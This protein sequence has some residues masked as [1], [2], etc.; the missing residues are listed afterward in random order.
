M[1]IRTLSYLNLI[2]AVIYFLAYLQNGSF[3]AITGILMVVVFNWMVLRGL[4]KDS[5]KWTAFQWVNAALSLLFA[6][7]ISYGATIL[8][9]DAISYQYYP[10]SSML[11]S[12]S[13]I[14]FA[15]SIFFHVY[16]AFRN[17][18]TK[19]ADQLFDN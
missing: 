5:P 8:L 7:Y 18:I 3:E 12:G 14:L 6:V 19:K 2:F 11:L 4:E 9:L 17:R 13:G 15:L 10:M 1:M 16:L